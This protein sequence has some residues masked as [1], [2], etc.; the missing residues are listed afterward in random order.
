M[1]CMNMEPVA[2]IEDFNG[3]YIQREKQFINNKYKRNSLQASDCFLANMKKPFLGGRK[4]S[5]VY[6]KIVQQ[7]SYSQITEYD[8]QDIEIKK[9]L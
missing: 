9:V 7:I 4:K 6:C 5:L 2:V 1:K 8:S 3:T